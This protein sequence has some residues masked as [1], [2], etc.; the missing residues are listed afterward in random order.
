MPFAAGILLGLASYAS[1]KIVALALGGRTTCPGRKRKEAEKPAPRNTD[2]TNGTNR[3]YGSISPIHL[4][5]FS[6]RLKALA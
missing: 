6:L 5:R 3:T 1:R 2:R 4:P